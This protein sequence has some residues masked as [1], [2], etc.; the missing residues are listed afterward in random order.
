MAQTRPCH[1][2]GSSE[3]RLE[4]PPTYL[5]HPDT[6]SALAHLPVEL[7]WIAFEFAAS[8][9]QVTAANLVRVSKTVREW[10]VVILY[11]TAILQTPRSVLS[12]YKTITVLKPHFASNIKELYLPSAPSPHVP[13]SFL[14]CFPALQHL[15]ISSLSLRDWPSLL[16]ASPRPKSVTITGRLGR[17][18]FEHP[19]FKYCTHL[20]LADDVPAP[21]VLTRDVLPCLTHLACAYRHGSSSITAITCLPL[22]LSQ[23]SGGNA[24][25]HAYRQPFLQV[26]PGIT[27]PV[28]LKVLV[29]GLYLSNG[30]P[31]ATMFVLERLGMGKKASESNLRADPRL[32][33]RP[34]KAL[35]ARRW[36]KHVISNV[37]WS[38]AERE[39]RLQRWVGNICRLSLLTCL[40]HS[41]L[42]HR[43]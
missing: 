41:L 3:V 28:E 35:T 14:T 26:S 8:Q 31:D 27:S 21:F 20:I 15:A 25:W 24:Y 7:V 6:R 2:H 33:L 5:S 13:S 12:F 11:R 19:I 10:I 4:F 23:K 17:L 16:Q 37:L 18:S 29:L 30:S 43:V 42:K 40:G 32:V 22:L 1:V 38:R 36:E 9:S 39:V 34:G